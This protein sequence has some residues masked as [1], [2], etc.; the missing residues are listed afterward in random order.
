MS[1][2]RKLAILLIGGIL[3]VCF[4]NKNVYA[5]E[6]NNIPESQELYKVVKEYDFSNVNFELNEKGD[7]KYKFN[8]M[9]R[10]NQEYEV[11]DF[12]NTKEGSDIIREN[13]KNNIKP[14]GAK[15][16][17]YYFVENTEDVEEKGP[18]KFLT[19]EEYEQSSKLRAPSYGYFTMTV[20]ASPSTSWGKVT[21]W[22]QVK[23]KWTYPNSSR[24]DSSP[25]NSD[26][27]IQLYSG[28]FS[29]VNV[30]KSF[31]GGYKQYYANAFD[32]YYGPIT[33]YNVSLNDKHAAWRF[34]DKLKSSVYM[35]T[36]Y[37]GAGFTKST[38]ANRPGV[39]MA[40]YTHTY[41]TL[42]TALSLGGGNY[43]TVN[44]ISQKWDLTAESNRVN[45]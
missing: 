17:R 6:I 43:V 28:D 34:A 39:F 8:W 15:T 42:N 37:A 33:G 31:S 9:P 44:N 30:S 13:L 36:V 5:S 16:T 29:F 21:Y 23:A 1:F 12:I 25:A 10:I 45:F 19:N 7:I 3:N 40:R 24:V 18:I 20:S 2:K 35:D 32:Q 41:S 11:Q 14:K 4:L 27:L 26:D 22:T 38:P